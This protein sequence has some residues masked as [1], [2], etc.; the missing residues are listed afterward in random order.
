MDVDSSWRV[1]ASERRSL[2]DLLEQLREQGIDD[3]RDVKKCCLESDGKMSVIRTKA[4]DTP[5]PVAKRAS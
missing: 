3:V 5:R 2:A 1:I 4:D